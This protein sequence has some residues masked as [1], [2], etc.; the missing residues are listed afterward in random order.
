MVLVGAA[1]SRGIWIARYAGRE[2][3]RFRVVWEA[4][5]KSAGNAVYMM[6][7]RF[8]A[9]AMVLDFLGPFCSRQIEFRRG[10]VVRDD[11]AFEALCVKRHALQM[12]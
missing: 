12:R 10:N 4:A 1:S 5:R 9:T 7:A 3:G 2:R 6:R 11:G 8:C